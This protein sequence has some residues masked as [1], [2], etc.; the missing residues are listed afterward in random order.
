[1][2]CF[3]C[4]NFELMLFSIFKIGFHSDPNRKREDLTGIR[5]NFWKYETILLGFIRSTLNR[6]ASSVFQTLHILYKPMAIDHLVRASFVIRQFLMFPGMKF[7]EDFDKRKINIFDWKMPWT[8]D[9][10]TP[11]LE[12]YTHFFKLND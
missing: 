5:I 3:L 7:I 8:L 11:L 1:M 10:D 9:T 6:H 2:K 12:K 4:L